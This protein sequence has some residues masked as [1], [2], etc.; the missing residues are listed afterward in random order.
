MSPG[1]GA[2]P[3]SSRFLRGDELRRPGKRSR[4]MVDARFSDTQAVSAPQS[5]Y[6]AYWRGIAHHQPTHYPI[7][8][9]LLDSSS[10][11][12]VRSPP[13]LDPHALR[14]LPGSPRLDLLPYVLS[15]QRGFVGQRLNTRVERSKHGRRLIGYH[16]IGKPVRQF[17]DLGRAKAFYGCLDLGHCGHGCT[18]AGDSPLASHGWQISGVGSAPCP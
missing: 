14:T 17:P 5:P 7:A 16:A 10:R 8:R 3:R 13:S 6:A 18:L 9:Q 15:G 11:G 1:P 12:S 4:T 2:R